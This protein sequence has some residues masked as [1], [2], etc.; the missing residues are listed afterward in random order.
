MR[1]NTGVRIG[2]KSKRFIIDIKRATCA[3]LRV[4]VLSADNSYDEYLLSAEV[5]TRLR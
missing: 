1:A 4:I 5:I 2:S 3:F